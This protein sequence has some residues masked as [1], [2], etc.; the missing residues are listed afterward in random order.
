MG[1]ASKWVIGL[2]MVSLFFIGISG[3]IGEFETNYNMDTGSQFAN[4]TAAFEDT[5]FADDIQA[6]ADTAEAQWDNSNSAEGGLLG[7]ALSWPGHMLKTFA[8]VFSAFFNVEPVAREMLSETADATGLS[9]QGQGDSNNG[10]A[11][12]AI[13]GTIIGMAVIFTITRLMTGRDV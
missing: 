3:F 13:L 5:S 2:L 9:A 8:A 1:Q 4:I 11:I 6:N 10:A 12:V 7:W